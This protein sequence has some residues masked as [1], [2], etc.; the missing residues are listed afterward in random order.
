MSRPGW[1]NPEISWGNILSMITM[2]IVGVGAFYAMDTRQQLLEQRMSAVEAQAR[3][4]QSDA[5]R[6]TRLEEQMLAIKDIVL[7]VERAVEMNRA[8]RP[9]R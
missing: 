9:A 1:F 7:R 5:D 3:D 4:R 2:V 6:L 8:I